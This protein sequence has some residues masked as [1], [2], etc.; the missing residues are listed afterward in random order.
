MAA[1]QAALSGD[2]LALETWLSAYNTP[3]ATNEN[4]QNRTILHCAALSGSIPCVEALLRYKSID[5]NRTDRLG[6][7]P[8]HCACT[9][10]F[11]HIS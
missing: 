1:H 8:L 3:N 4:L 6:L 7:T 2:V 11:F 5:L 10:M 9:F